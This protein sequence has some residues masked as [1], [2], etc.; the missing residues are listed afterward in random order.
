ME[1]M[2]EAPECTDRVDPVVVVGERVRE[3]LVLA[4]DLT[5]C[6]RRE[7][8][9]TD[10]GARPD[11]SDTVASDTGAS[12]TGASAPD[13]SDSAGAGAGAGAGFGVGLVGPLGVC[14]EG[15]S[16][17]GLVGWAKDLEELSRVVMALQVQVAGV[18]GERVRAGRF[19]AEGIRNP[20]DLLSLSLL[21]GRAEGFA[22]LR[23]AERILPVMDPVT[24]VVSAP[25]MPVVG[26]AFFAGEVS[27]DRALVVCSFVDEAAHLVQGGR[28][29]VG[30]VRRLE[31]TLSGYARVEPPEFLRRI[32]ARAV[33]VLDPDGQE[34]TEGELLSRQGIFFRRPRR[35]LIGFDGHM[36]IVQY[37]KLMSSVAWAA[38][39]NK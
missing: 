39:P 13:R 36:T 28:I 11:A 14:L 38:N 1:A 15:F 7:V 35:G 8:A 34:P 17:V 20:V 29:E 19:E 25:L 32:G 33:N 21:V 3:L 24:M 30:E 16:D 6:A 4:Q 22:R 5:A 2:V 23:L 9:R 26:A 27:A 10:A 31:E 12:D 18:L 37:E